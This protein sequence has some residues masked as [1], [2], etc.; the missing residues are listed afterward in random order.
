VHE[1]VAE[2]KHTMMIDNDQSNIS[3]VHDIA[4]VSSGAV[5]KGLEM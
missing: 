1:Y 3:V 4:K 5:N 2:N